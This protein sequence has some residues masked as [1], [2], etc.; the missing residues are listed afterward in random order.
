VTE[1]PH[2]SSRAKAWNESLAAHPGELDLRITADR[3]DGAIPPALRGGRLLSNGPGWNV[4][5]GRTLHPFDGHGYVRAFRFEPDG[6]V[7]LTAR[8]V[9]TPSYLAERAAGHL[10]DRGLATN[11]TPAW[12]NL[13]PG[14]ARNVANTTIT[15][16]RDRL[17]AGWEGGAPH[18]L[19]PRTLATRGEETF[20]GVLA[21]QTTLAHVKHEA[22]TGRLV[23][24]SLQTGPRMRFTIR[25]LDVDERVCAT[26]RAEL[27]GLAFVHDFAISPE[28]VVVGGNPIRM[29][30][31]GV[32]GWLLGTSTLLQALAT[33]PRAGGALHLISRTGGAMRTVRLPEPGWIVHFGN[34]FEREGTLVVDACVLPHFVFGEEFGYGGPTRPFDPTR[35]EQRGKQTLYR[36]TIPR[37]ATEAQWEPL[38]EHG[39]DFPR[40]HPAHEGRETPALFGATRADTR[41]SDP[42]DAIV[43]VDLLDRDRPDALFSTPPNTFVG[44]PI[45]VPSPD[46][47]EAGHVLVIVT[48]ALDARSELVVLD[49][50]A[51]E[52]GPLAVVPLPLLPLAFHGDWDAALSD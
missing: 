42:F 21:G 20:G 15:R 38:T 24:F 25:E 14:R 2:T 37:G 3:I 23:T 27:D 52:K 11:L 35:P 31:A 30:P 17:L 10:V 32:A 36:I 26:H 18:A 43:R 39:V 34:A 29:K 28:W 6:S 1:A 46:R 33:D 4:I 8:F 22:R 19:D 49:A 45:F 47:P 40:V 44:E 48:R 13:V 16:W 7:Q 50:L 9:E 12:R 5:G 51:L 41:F